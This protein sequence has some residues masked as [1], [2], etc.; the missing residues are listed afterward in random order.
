MQKTYIN[1]EKEYEA[2]KLS[3]LPPKYYKNTAYGSTTP[4]RYDGNYINIQAPNI[5]VKKPLNVWKQIKNE[6]TPNQYIEYSGNSSYPFKSAYLKVE[7]LDSANQEILALNENYIPT[8]KQDTEQHNMFKFIYNVNKDALQK[9]EKEDPS[10]STSKKNN[11]IKLQT[12]ASE[13]KNHIKKV[14][15]KL[16]EVNTCYFNIK[17]GSGTTIK[18]KV[19][20]LKTFE[21]K[22][23]NEQTKEITIVKVRKCVETFEIDNKS[24]QDMRTELGSSA[25]IKY[26]FTISGIHVGNTG[27]SLQTFLSEIYLLPI[28]SGEINQDI[29]DSFSTETVSSN[30]AIDNAIDNVINNVFNN[31]DG[32]NDYLSTLDL[33]KENAA[34]DVYTD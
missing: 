23:T 7:G 28:E 1:L 17:V 5:M 6:G 21:E 25:E 20:L 13:N 24:L 15:K 34:D 16:N 14:N 30:N 33:D 18:T 4:I 19:N 31:D 9:I 22:R 29:I 26:I 8:D 10:L 32:I 11:A 3:L 2:H 27:V 12:T